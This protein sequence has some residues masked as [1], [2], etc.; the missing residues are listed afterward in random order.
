MPIIAFSPSE[1]TRRK[2]ALYWGVVPCPIEPSTDADEIVDRANG[3]CMA[4]GFASPGD[5]MVVVFGAPLG[6]QGTTN[7]IRVR[8]AG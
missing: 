1:R 6:V 5:R 2:L 4:R 8:V 7:T 3:H